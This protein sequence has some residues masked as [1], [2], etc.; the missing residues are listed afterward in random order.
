MT[1]SVFPRHAHKQGFT[2]VAYK[3]DGTGIITGGHDSLLRIFD[4]SPAERNSEPKTLDGHSE[5]VLTIATHKTNFASAGDDG[6]VLVYRN[7]TNDFEKFLVRS[8]VPVRSLSFNSNGTKIAVAT[9]EQVIR[10]VLLRDISK[11]V[12]L[13]GHAHLVKSVAFSPSSDHMISTDCGG[14]VKVWDMNHAS[15]A[16]QCIKTLP[17]VLN[18]CSSDADVMN[19]VAWSPDGAYF[20]YAGKEHE[21]CVHSTSDWTKKYSLE[22]AHFND[23]VTMAWSPNGHYLCSASKD[24][25][26]VIWD[27]TK[28]DTVTKYENATAIS[29]IAWHPT[30]NELAFTDQSGAL[31]VWDK[32][33]NELE[34]KHPAHRASD[35]MDDDLDR[36]FEDEGQT[37]EPSSIARDNILDEAVEDEDEGEEIDD[38]E[39]VDMLSDMGDFVIDDDGAG[40][41]EDRHHRQTTK[42]ARVIERGPQYKLTVQPRFQPGATAFRMMETADPSVPVAGERRYMAYNMFGIIYTIYQ[43]THSVVN[44]EFHNQGDNRNFHFKDDYHFTMAAIGKRGIVFGVEGGK[45]KQKRARSDDDDEEDEEDESGVTSSVIH[46]RPLTNWVANA[47]WTVLLPAGENVLSVSINEGAVIAVTSAGY[48]RMYTISGLQTLIFR[49]E[50]IVA[51]VAS[52]AMAMFVYKNN[53]GLNGE[54]NLEFMLMDTDTQDVVQKGN[55]PLQKNTQLTWIGFSEASQALMYDSNHVLSILHRQRNLGQSY[56]IPVFDGRA[57]AQALQR[58]ER[59]WPI[60]M[61]RDRLM[62]LTVRG[63]NESPYFPMPPVDDMELRMPATSLET[64]AGQLEERHMRTRVIAMHDRAEAVATHREDEYYDSLNAIDAEMDKDLLRLIQ[65][66]CRS[67]KGQ[68]VYDLASALLLPRSVDAAVKIASHFK[69]TTIAEKLIQIKEEKFMGDEILSLSKRSMEMDLS[70]DDASSKRARY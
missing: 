8:T 43:G 44:V 25:Q 11:V 3:T 38:G 60:G 69:L 34:M 53:M 62:C 48:V 35:Q 68:R 15:G 13:E 70:D 17:G 61:H 9:D 45:P 26:V 29:D 1:I 64:E 28:R 65:L 10:V 33:I 4:S 63:N 7:A 30:E 41:A 22:Y 49:M 47:D 37:Q 16:P 14:D 27:A 12:T 54:Q 19:T 18:K 6:S 51:T 46:Y 59:Y 24:R 31:V 23:I 57:T 21:I 42:R 58:T 52:D 2:I 66:A 56:W 40:Y 67:D 20:C 5:P 50:N 36:L 32:P 55:L 39:D